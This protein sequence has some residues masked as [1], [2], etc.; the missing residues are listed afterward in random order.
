MHNTE[1]DKNWLSEILIN[2]INDAVYLVDTT[3]GGLLGCNDAACKML[4]YSYEE[5]LKM[6]VPDICLSITDQDG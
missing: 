2:Q 5:L 3:T 6:K 4:G 1:L